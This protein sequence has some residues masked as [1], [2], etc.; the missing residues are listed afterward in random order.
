MSLIIEEH[1]PITW[2]IVVWKI[3]LTQAY[4]PEKSVFASKTLQNIIYCDHE[5]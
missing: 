5:W 1:I 4:N 3:K 2:L